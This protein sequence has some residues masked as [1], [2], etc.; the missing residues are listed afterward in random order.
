MSTRTSK[1]IEWAGWGAI[2]YF[3]A[4]YLGGAIASRFSVG[5]PRFQVKALRPTFFEGVLSIPIQNN[6]PASIPIDGFKGQLLYGQY[7]LAD[8][9]VNQSFSLPAKDQADMNVNVYVGYGDF[10]GNLVD[11]ISRGDF[12]QQLRVKGHVYSAGLVVP[13]DNTIQLV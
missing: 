8:V 13:I 9:A 2:L 7:K 6:T 12:L 11:L 3:A 5:M 10:T 4:K 1:I